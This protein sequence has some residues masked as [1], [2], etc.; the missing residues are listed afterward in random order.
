MLIIPCS[1]HM[2]GRAGKEKQKK[3]KQMGK[4]EVETKEAEGVVDVARVSSRG[5]AA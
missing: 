2:G 4:E 1:Q 5:T 3:E